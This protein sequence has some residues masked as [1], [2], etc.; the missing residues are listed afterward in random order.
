MADIG[1]FDSTVSVLAKALDLRA[2]NQQ[3]IASNIANAETPGFAPSRLDF[4][5]KLRAAID[6]KSPSS[7]P[8]QERHFPL[9]SSRIDDVRGDVITDRSADIGDGNGV[10]LDDEMVQMAENQIYYQAATQMISKKFALLKYA[11]GGGR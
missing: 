5:A 10:S 4:E 6:V 1:L 11:A 3:L 2:Q 8:R 7:G 9:S